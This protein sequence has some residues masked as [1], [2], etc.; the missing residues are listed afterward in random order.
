MPV[1]SAYIDTSVL[2]AYYCPEA[3][4][5]AAEEAILRLGTPVISN[6][7]EVEFCSLVAKKCRL[8]E[9]KKRQAR[10]IIDLFSNH[11]AEGFYRRM[12]LTAE[13]FIKARTLIASMTSSLRSLDAL[14]LAVATSGGLNL[15]TAD[16]EFARAAKS[17]KARALLLK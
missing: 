16:L 11:V 4:S 6:L 7:S 15:V 13:H 9:L 8:N 2:G 12:P 5:A 1:E 17:L 3:L 14:H 10:E